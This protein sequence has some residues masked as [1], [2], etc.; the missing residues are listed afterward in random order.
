[1]LAY[2][3]Y[4]NCWQAL[5]DVASTHPYNTACAQSL[6]WR[7]VIGGKEGRMHVE[8]LCDCWLQEVFG[9]SGFS[10]REMALA[11]AHTVCQNSCFNF[12]L[13]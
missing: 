10:V 4:V 2:D 1:M 12:L 3:L 13:F 8:P 9:K 5:I 7:V 6:A 11:G